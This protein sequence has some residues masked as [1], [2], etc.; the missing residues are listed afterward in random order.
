M[1]TLLLC[2]S[3]AIWITNYTHLILLEDKQR[4]WGYKKL[5]FESN[6]YSLYQITVCV[7]STDG[8]VLDSIGVC[9]CQT[10]IFVYT[11]TCV[12]FSQLW[13]MYS[14]MN[15]EVNKVWGIFSYHKAPFILIYPFNFEFY[16]QFCW[17][18]Q[19][20]SFF[21]FIYLLIFFAVVW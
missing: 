11:Y 4:D 8:E 21:L 13:I 2:Q 5:V 9:P 6:K 18:I 20:L 12:S 14:W 17:L 3:L 7:N 19:T 10:C 15:L 1:N 16:G